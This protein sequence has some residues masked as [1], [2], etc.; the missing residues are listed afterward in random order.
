MRLS[1][2]TSGHSLGRKALL[3]LVRL[4]MRARPPDVVRT[5]FYR[6]GF[7]GDRMSAWTNEIMR[8][9]SEWSVG[10]RELFAAFTSHLNQCVY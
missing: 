5:L 8:G 6:P 4:A 2:V 10:E 7:W 3:L 9:P 1:R